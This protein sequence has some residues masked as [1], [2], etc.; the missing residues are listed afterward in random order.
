MG[1]MTMQK[2]VFRNFVNASNYSYEFIYFKHF[3]IQ[4]MHNT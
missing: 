3:V 1:N 4:L 2:F